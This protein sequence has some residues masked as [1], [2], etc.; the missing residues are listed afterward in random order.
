MKRSFLVFFCVGCV[1]SCSAP[2]ARSESVFPDPG[3]TRP[4]FRFHTG[5]VVNNAPELSA[6]LPDI[7]GEASGWYVAQWK[8]HDLLRPDSMSRDDDTYD[9]PRLGTP[10]YTFDTSS[11]E[12][13][14]KVF[15]SPS[16]A[17]VYELVASGGELTEAGGSAL[18]LAAKAARSDATF[19]QPIDL[20]MDMKLSEARVDAPLSAIQTGAVV[21]QVLS[22][23][24]LE[25]TEPETN[26]K[27]SV[28]LQMNHADSRGRFNEYRGCSRHG[29]KAQIVYSAML[30]G[31]YRMPFVPNGGALVHAS[32]NLNRH[33][34]RMLSQGF[35]CR[36][37]DGSTK[38]F[39][40]PESTGDLHNWRLTSMYIG[41]ETE[42]R[43]KRALAETHAKQ[44]DIDVAFQISNLRV[45][46]DSSRPAVFCVA[47]P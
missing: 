18:F 24:T 29:G 30:N 39:A 2:K 27:M 40:F 9:D 42:D 45:M 32:Y 31:E 36:E 47:A 4:K 20:S 35:S 23:F 22:G 15:A 34:C 37:P 33:L 26:S 1:L 41:L 21:A 10:L 3:L 13:Q 44:G 43:D 7:P 38:P 28:F 16:G 5:K 6:V 46:R 14:L 19:D 8:K 11:H 17:K 25:F 12:S